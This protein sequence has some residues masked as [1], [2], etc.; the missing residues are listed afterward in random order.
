MSASDSVALGTAIRI[1][2]GNETNCL[3]TGEVTACE[4]QYTADGHQNMILRSYDLLHRLRKRQHLR[5]FEDISLAG[6]VKELTGDLGLHIQVHGPAIRFRQIMQW[7]QS[8]LA[9]LN[10]NIQRYGRYFALWDDE[11]H[12]FSLSG[13]ERNM[14]ELEWERNLLSV[15]TTRNTEPACRSVEVFGWNPQTAEAVSGKAGADGYPEPEKHETRSGHSGV[16]GERFLTGQPLG[17][18]EEAAALGQAML[19]RR[20]AGEAVL[21]GVAEGNPL[22]R[23]GQQVCLAG[24]AAKQKTGRYVL[25]NVKHILNRSQGYLCEFD[26]FPPAFSTPKQHIQ[27]SMGVVSDIHDPENKGRIKVEFPDLGKLE[28]LWLEVT[29][30]GAGRNKGLIALPDA[31]D[32]VLVLFIDGNPSQGVVIG[33]LYGKAGPP[34][35]GIRSGGVKCYTFTTPGGQKL[36][37]DDEQGTVKVTNRDGS[38]IELHPKKVIL[39]AESDLTIEAPGKKML[40][41]ANKIDFEQ[42]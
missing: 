39:H 38:H 36:C 9:L 14:I 7:Q 28:S 10:E 32:Q 27:S 42:K 20:K 15:T 17:S 3:F 29:Y 31:G 41:R 35:D 5:Q 2:I 26:T 23:P 34:D 30:P 22:L 12:I 16:S 11:L 4:Q 25:S 33:G 19:E 40:F 24:V 8:D 1:W 18:T 13:I 37:L 21:Q 6:L